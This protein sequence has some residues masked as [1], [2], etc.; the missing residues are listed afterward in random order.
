MAPTR[1]LTPIPARKGARPRDLPEATAPAETTTANPGVR[2]IEP[3]NP[4]SSPRETVA[5]AATRRELHAILRHCPL[6]LLPV[7]HF[8]DRM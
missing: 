1:P 5:Q 2:L 8:S 4:G 7:R 3:G 6:R